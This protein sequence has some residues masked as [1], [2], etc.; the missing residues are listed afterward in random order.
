MQRQSFFIGLGLTA[1]TSLASLSIRLSASFGQSTTSESQPN[2]VTFFCRQIIDKASGE[3]IPATVAWIPERQGHIRFVGWK[4][5]YFSKSGLTPEKRC[6]K[7][8]A[9]FQESYDQGRLN[10]LSYGISNGYPIIC[11]LANQG[12]TCNSSN[13]LFTI[14]S[15][16]NSELVLRRLT[17]ISEG[18]SSDV[19]L[20]SSGEQVYLAVQD[21][22]KKTPLINTK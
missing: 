5:E 21:F 4:S 6:E 22:F 10:Y 14:K 8:T 3:N 16:S 9:K 17:D 12:E 7:V 13:Q 2:K 11:G 18:K 15:G 20:Q 19:L 1:L